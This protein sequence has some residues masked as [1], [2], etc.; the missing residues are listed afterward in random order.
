MKTNRL[1]KITA[2]FSAMAFLLAGCFTWRASEAATDAR[3]SRAALSSVKTIRVV[4]QERYGDADKVRLPYFDKAKEILER[5]GGFAIAG[6]AATGYDATLQITAEGEALGDFYGVFQ[7]RYSG[8]MV[9]GKLVFS[10]KDVR[11]ELPF[12][13]HVDPPEEIPWEACLTPNCAPFREAFDRAFYPALMRLLG[14]LRSI[15]CV[16][17]ALKDS[18]EHVREA[19]AAALGQIKDARAVEPLIAALKDS[20]WL[21]REAAAAALWNITG[22]RFGVDPR[23]W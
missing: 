22:Q 21:V 15:D 3:Q 8:A 23:A 6:E 1:M 18:D 10:A 5:Y 4:V 17:A 9:A 12:R 2:L 14:D 20:H 19:A 7:F 11:L 13:G 16:I